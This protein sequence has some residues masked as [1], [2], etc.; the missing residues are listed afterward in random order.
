MSS[1]WYGLVYILKDAAAEAAVVVAGLRHLQ[2]DENSARSNVPSSGSAARRQPARSTLGWLGRAAR[3]A[4]V[5]PARQL[6]AIGGR[7][8]NDD[9]RPPR[10]RHAQVDRDGRR[11]RAPAAT[12]ITRAPAARAPRARR[13]SRPR[14]QRN[15]C[16]CRELRVEWTR[17]VAEAGRGALAAYCPMR[18]HRREAD[19]AAATSVPRRD[20]R[21]SPERGCRPSSVKKRPEAGDA[22]CWDG[23]WDG[24]REVG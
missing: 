8:H 22:A 6:Y 10:A 9:R 24:H 23:R 5:R 14:G 11:R 1:I 16:G 7:E 17:I 13:S 18:A 3:V 19:A 20:G 2:E 4:H 15:L 12:L 21:C